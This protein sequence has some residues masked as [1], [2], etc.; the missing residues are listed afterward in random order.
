M[1]RF[2]AHEKEFK[3]KQFSKK[4][5]LSSSGR[6]AGDPDGGSGSDVDSDYGDDYDGEYDPEDGES[7]DKEDMLEKDREWLVNYL[8]TIKVKI[9]ALEADLEKP[10]L[11]GAQKK[12]KEKQLSTIV[13]VKDRVEDLNGQMDLVEGGTIRPLKAILEDFLMSSEEE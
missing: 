13:K 10:K 12:Q 5:L 8:L 3:K 7:E 6:R 2:R 9:Q 11:K 1:E 4:A